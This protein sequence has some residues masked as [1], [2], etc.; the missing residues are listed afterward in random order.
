[1][2]PNVKHTNGWSIASRTPWSGDRTAAAPVD[3]AELPVRLLDDR[4]GPMDRRGPA[5]IDEV[6]EGLLDRLQRG[7][8]Q[9]PFPEQRHEV[10]RDRLA[11]GKA[12]FQ[13]GWFEHGLDVLPVDVVGSIALH[14][15][16]HEVRGELHHPGSDVLASLLVETDLE[17]FDGLEESGEEKPNWSRPDDVHPA[18]RGQ[19]LERSSRGGREHVAHLARESRIPRRSPS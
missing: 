14:G 15:V 17:S 7:E 8:P 19:G 18:A 3:D 12:L 16:R 2:S 11:E 4:G 13:L 5:C 1:V 6:A 9:G 10:G